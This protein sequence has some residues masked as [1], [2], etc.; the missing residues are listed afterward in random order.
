MISLKRIGMACVL[1]WLTAFSAGASTTL[2]IGTTYG[3]TI[4]AAG[5]T[6]LYTF[7]ATAGQRLFFDALD[8]DTLGLNVSLLSPGGALLYQQNDDYDAGPWALAEAGMYSLVINGNS[9]T[10][11]NYEFRVLDLGTAPQLT[12]GTPFSDQLS[13]PQSC[14]LYQFNGKRGQRIAL[15][16]LDFSTNQ[17]RWQLVSP[18]NVVVVSGQFTASLG[19]VTL[20]LD[21][22]YCVMVIG[23]S[24]GNTPLTYQVLANDVSDTPVA[25]SGFGTIHSGTVSA[26]QTNSFTYTAPAG[27]PIYFDSLDTSGQ[28]K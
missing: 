28:S 8:V 13:P 1:V 10:T 18:A 3:G 22:P 2:T 17:A 12:M 11:G 5:Q 23:T 19:P 6:N 14:N 9:S 7:N 20:P 27:L 21:G 4:A 16:A 25:V 15:Q 24:V 26:N